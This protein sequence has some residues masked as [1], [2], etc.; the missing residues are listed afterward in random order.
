MGVEEGKFS[1]LVG[2]KGT[3]DPK[4]RNS[5]QIICTC[6][7]YL[8]LQM[9]NCGFFLTSH[10][11]KNSTPA[12]RGGWS[13]V[14]AVRK[15]NVVAKQKQRRTDMGKGGKKMEGWDDGCV[16]LV[17]CPLTKTLMSVC[18]IP[19]CLLCLLI[20]I[21]YIHLALSSSIPFFHPPSFCPP[22]ITYLLSEPHLDQ[23]CFYL[24]AASL[25]PPLCHPLFLPPFSPS[26]SFCCRLMSYLFPPLHLVLFSY[27]C[28]WQV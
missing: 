3:N 5:K 7:S 12:E 13:T 28:A 9:F 10:R 15:R 18:V 16:A 20:L 21:N 2:K 4:T 6:S 22:K 14:G 11:R 27:R 1:H 25:C 17:L 24:L 8:L 23:T 19:L 26:F